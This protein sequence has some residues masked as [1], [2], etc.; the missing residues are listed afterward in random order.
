MIHKQ[1]IEEAG[2]YVLDIIKECLNVDIVYIMSRR[3]DKFTVMNS[4]YRD[5]CAVLQGE[6]LNAVNSLSSLVV[7]NKRTLFISN[8]HKAAEFSQTML[9][10]SF[11]GVP[12]YT[13]GEIQGV[14]CAL[15]REP[16]KHLQKD[17]KLLEGLASIIGYIVE[18]K[19]VTLKDGLTGLYN[20]NYID[21]VSQQWAQ[22]KSYISLIYI[23]IDNFKSINDRYGH[24][25]GDEVLRSLSERFKQII[26]G[27][28]VIIRMGGDEFIFIFESVEREGEERLLAVAETLQ[29]HMRQ[30]IQTEQGAILVSISIGI[31]NGSLTYMSI[32]ELIQ[33]ADKAMYSVKHN[34]KAA[35]ELSAYRV[36]G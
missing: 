25:T 9:T 20:R 16:T 32:Q 13:R 17:I 2:Q 31:S 6:R 35:Y 4:F 27:Q 8:L 29:N 26:G 34:G 1:I 30:P 12:I 18:L 22:A 14:I 15:S 7:K 33:Q 23:D 11:V 24:S 36:I 21:Y 10:D 5:N 28:D 3:N 19:D